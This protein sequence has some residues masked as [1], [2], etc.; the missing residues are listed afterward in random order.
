M[1]AGMMIRILIREAME[2]RKIK[3]RSTGQKKGW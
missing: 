1:I 2:A 3:E